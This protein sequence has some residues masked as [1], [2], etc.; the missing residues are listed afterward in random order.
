MRVSALTLGIGVFD[1]QSVVSRN[2]NERRSVF[3][4][5]N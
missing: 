5:G 4:C 3:I 1:K 2:V